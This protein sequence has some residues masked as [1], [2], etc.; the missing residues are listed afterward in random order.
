MICL[1]KSNPLRS[2][3]ISKFSD[4]FQTRFSLFT[5]LI[6]HPWMLEK[7][8][9][10]SMTKNYS[11]EI[12]DGALLPNRATDSYKSDFGRVVYKKLC[13]LWQHEPQNQTTK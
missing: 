8:C 5:N 12:V 11:I 13:L 9:F 4:D 2:E 3:R 6:D 7:L 1:I 10:S